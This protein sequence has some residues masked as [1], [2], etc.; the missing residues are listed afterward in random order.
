MTEFN[1]LCKFL[2]TNNFN[3]TIVEGPRGVGK[4]TFC[5]KLLEV[6]DL[7]YYK[8]WGGEQRD[9]RFRMEG[10][11]N[12]SLPQGTYFVLD[13]VR[14]VPP[15]RPVLADRGNISA[16]AYQ[17]E[18]P[19]GKNSEL[20]KYYVDLMRESRSVMLVL[21]GPE[22]VLLRRRISRKDE[23]EFKLYTL[24]EG[25]A[26]GLVRRDY[27]AYEE[28]VAMMVNAGL[29]NVAAF[30]LDDCCVCDAYIASGMEVTLPPEGN[31]EY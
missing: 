3:V 9:V 24:P 29:E 11:L 20:H 13:F 26:K 22:D 1:V 19:Y 6:S 27:E 2:Q 21:S 12:L 18:F 15:A 31:Y 8:T 14:Q 7:I 30:D 16:L 10:D 17:R 25:N 23:D 4:T 5:N 28:S